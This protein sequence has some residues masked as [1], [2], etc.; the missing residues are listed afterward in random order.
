MKPHPWLYIYMNWLL[1]ISYVQIVV[2]MGILM[3]LKLS[4]DWSPFEW[5]VVVCYVLTGD[6]R[7]V[8]DKMPP[9]HV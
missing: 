9:M 6:A 8:F 5:I 7:H 4:I 3:H 1:F 2:C